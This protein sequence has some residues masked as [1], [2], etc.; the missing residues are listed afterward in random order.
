MT[1]GAP[2]VKV[3]THVHVITNILLAQ[4]IKLPH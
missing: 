1:V 3:A 2:D 4:I